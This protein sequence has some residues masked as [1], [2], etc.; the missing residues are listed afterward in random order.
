M[1]IAVFFTLGMG[2]K[3]LDEAGLLNREIAYYSLLGEK[4]LINHIFFF[5]YDWDIKNLKL[6][7]DIHEI[8]VIIMP[9]VFK[10]FGKTGLLFYSLL[11]P[12]LHRNV[13]KSVS[14]FKSNQT[15]GG[16]TAY[17]AAKLHNGIFV[18][19]TGYFTSSLLKSSDFKLWK[20]I[21]YIVYKILE[22]QLLNNSQVSIVSSKHNFNYA[23][24]RCPEGNIFLINNPID[25]KLF[26]PRGDG[27]S[28]DVFLY[29]GRLSNEKNLIELVDA[30]IGSDLKLRLVG[31][32]PL[33]DNL[34]NKIKSHSNIDFKGQLN[35]EDLLEQLHT[36]KYFCN[37]SHHEGM[38]KALL[39]AMSMGKV[40]VCTPTEAANEIIKDSHNGFITSGFKS[41]DIQETLFRATSC[42]DAQITKMARLSVAEKY[43]LETAT[44]LEVSLYET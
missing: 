25:T 12:L 33:K 23:T 24:Q 41:G 37:V 26:K 14:I 34:I 4:K 36:A 32:G 9:K 30:F 1:N 39:E 43:S 18:Y 13:L 19:R 10:Y 35:L 44:T 22:Q 11:M 5:T 8:S 20:Y 7:F 16:W 28:Q 27:H 2:I 42:D 3:K 40:C 6:D 15:L 21:K 38:P 29:V 31:D 17:L